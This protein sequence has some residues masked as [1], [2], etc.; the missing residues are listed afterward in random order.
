MPL[1]TLMPLLLPRCSCHAALI[2]AAP[3]HDAAA[4]A[5]DYY[6]TRGDA[7]YAMKMSYTL[8]HV[9]RGAGELYGMP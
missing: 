6:V 2:D 1:L 8:Q 5:Y 7:R 3:L 4:A 9:A